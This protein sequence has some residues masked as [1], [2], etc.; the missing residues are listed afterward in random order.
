LSDGGSVEDSRVDPVG[1]GAYGMDSHNFQRYVVASSHARNEGDI[2]V[3]PDDHIEWDRI[4][5]VMAESRFER[6]IV[7]DY[8]LYRKLYRRDV[9]ERY[10][11][12]CVDTRMAIYRRL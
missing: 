9:Y 12:K 7:E 3:W 11:D 8:L 2:H 4:D 5:A 1:L 6:V 10:R